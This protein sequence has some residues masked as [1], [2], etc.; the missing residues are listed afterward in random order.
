M[1]MIISLY[2]KKCDVPQIITKVDYTDNSNIQDS[3]PLGSVVCP[4]DL[5]CM[6]ICRCLIRYVRLSELQKP[7]DLV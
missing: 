7:V 1:N 3:L 6:E 2:G 5:C 4:K